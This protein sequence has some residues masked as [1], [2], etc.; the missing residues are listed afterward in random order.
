[1]AIGKLVQIHAAFDAVEQSSKFLKAPALAMPSRQARVLG[2]GLRG[3]SNASASLLFKPWLKASSRDAADEASGF[4]ASVHPYRIGGISLPFHIGGVCLFIYGSSIQYCPATS[5]EAQ[6]SWGHLWG[7]QAVINF[8]KT[9]LN[10]GLREI[11]ESLRAH[12]FAFQA[13]PG[14]PINPREIG[15]LLLLVRGN[16]GRPIEMISMQEQWPSSW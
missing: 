7:N 12:Q 16:P 13:C 6:Q 1:M 11:F 3:R 8:K 2:P 14:I 15:G 4:R 9:I 10:K 5:N